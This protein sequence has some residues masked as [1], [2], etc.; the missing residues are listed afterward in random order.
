VAIVCGVAIVAALGLALTKFGG[1]RSEAPSPSGFGSGKA[2]YTDDDG[3]TWFADDAGRTSP[4]DH[5]GKQAYRC[6]VW[7]C[8]GGKSKFVSHLERLKPERLKEVQAGGPNKRADFILPS[9]D[10][11]VKP[12]L[13][14]DHGWTG[15]SK[16]GA[17]AIRTPHT[18]PGQ[19]GTPVAVEPK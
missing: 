1:G 14:G 15:Y 13:T 19:G 11:E 9:M 4:F 12:P 10:L 5:N 7:T 8:D 3:R 2:W 6:Y 18:P 17:E 16:P